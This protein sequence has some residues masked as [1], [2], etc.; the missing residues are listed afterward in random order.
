MKWSFDLSLPVREWLP[1]VVYPGFRPGM[2]DIWLGRLPE[3]IVRI[4]GNPFKSWIVENH[5]EREIL[6][7]KLSEPM[8]V[9][10]SGQLDFISGPDAAV[11]KKGQGLSASD[12]VIALY[13]PPEPGWPFFLLVSM[14]AHEEGFERGCYA[15]ETF[16]SEG[17]AMAHGAV[18]RDQ[19]GLPVEI[20]GP[21]SL[22]RS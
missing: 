16:D 18:L 20:M 15:W 2:P 11:R 19:I 4:T 9:L 10:P 12:F 17:E 7:R 8:P 3:Q 6:D 22:I 5:K 14:P 13:S 1:V 21:E